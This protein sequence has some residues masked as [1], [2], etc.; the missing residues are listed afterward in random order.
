ME[1]I[2]CYLQAVKFALPQKQQDDIV[3]E[4]RDNLLSQVEERE[5]VLGRPLREQEQAQ[6][7]KRLGNAVLLANRYGGQK[8]MIGAPIFPI[9]KRVLTA[10]LGIALLVHA[11]MSIALLLQ[12]SH[13]ARAWQCYFI[14]LESP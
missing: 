3:R 7:V 4:L 12:A 13:L 11:G 5:A 14:F 8:H 6:I 2:E 9:Y 1:L 10:A